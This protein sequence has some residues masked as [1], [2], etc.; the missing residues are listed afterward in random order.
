MPFWNLCTS[1]VFCALVGDAF[2]NF[3]R[4]FRNF[5]MLLPQNYVL[6]H[7]RAM[8]LAALGQE[9]HWP[10]WHDLEHLRTLELKLVR[11]SK[12]SQKDS[13]SSTL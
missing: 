6:M 5:R 12:S 11:S 2:F 7:P 13:A 1:A 8:H 3:L 9:N 4:S 10:R